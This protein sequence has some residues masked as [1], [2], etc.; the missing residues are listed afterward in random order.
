MKKYFYIKDESKI[1][2]FNIEDLKLEGIKRDT[3]IWF[4]GI[5]NWTKASE[6]TELCELFIHLPPPIPNVQTK[7]Y[8]ISLQLLALTCIV[9]SVIAWVE[10]ESIVVA[11]AGE[12]FVGGR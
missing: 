10:I 11:I 1:G 2:P 12:S 7:K 9:G 5:K 4:Q 6:V 8:R 3:L